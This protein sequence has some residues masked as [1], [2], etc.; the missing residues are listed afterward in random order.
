L[1]LIGGG[2]FLIYKAT[3]E[4]HAEFEES[5]YPTNKIQ[6]K[7]ANFTLI[8]LQIAVF[9]I[10]FS[11]DSILTAIGMTQ[12]FII[13]AV[14]ITI[15]III[16]ILGSE[17]LSQFINRHPTIRMLALSFLLLIGVVLIA[18][19]LKFHIPKAYIYFAVSFSVFVEILNSWLKYKKAQNEKRNTN[20]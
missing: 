8:V 20:L 5:D 17:P 12:N 3:V 16:M 6:K 9:D 2:L 14:A 7:F 19:G 13:M 10:I 1:L 4:I 11:L 15:A 18:D